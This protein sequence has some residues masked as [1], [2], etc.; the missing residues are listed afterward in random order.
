M[1]TR[2]P[3]SYSLWSFYFCKASHF[4]SHFISDFS[5]LSVSTI[6]IAMVAEVKLTFFFLILN[7]PTLRIF[8]FFDSPFFI[9]FHH[10]SEGLPP[11]TVTLL[12]FTQF[13]TSTLRCQW[14]QTSCFSNIL[15]FPCGPALGPAIFHP[16]A[17]WPTPV[18]HNMF[19]GL[20][21]ESCAPADPPTFSCSCAS[22][23]CVGHTESTLVLCGPRLLKGPFWVNAK[24][25]VSMGYFVD[26]E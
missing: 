16:F 15:S 5:N 21:T 26:K 22:I 23:C 6:C 14:T 12:E 18:L 1:G 11:L 13:L 10:K 2:S 7:E 8:F 4:L 9:H 19:L 20:Q 24:L 25:E 3:S 17:I